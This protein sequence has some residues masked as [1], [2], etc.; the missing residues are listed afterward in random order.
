MLTVVAHRAYRMQS[1]GE[2]VA[3]V[4]GLMATAMSF[5]VGRT[6]L[7]AIIATVFVFGFY[8]RVC[9][10]GGIADFFKCLDYMLFIGF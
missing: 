8:R 10:R 2:L 7:G 6:A 1:S 4:V 9:V 3:K 5:R